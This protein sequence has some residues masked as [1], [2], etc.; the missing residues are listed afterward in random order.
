[1]APW[2]G[3]NPLETGRAGDAP[4]GR[5]TSRAGA[6]SAPGRPFPS[7]ALSAQRPAG[8]YFRGRAAPGGQAGGGAGATAPSLRSGTGGRREEAAGKD[9]TPTETSTGKRQ[10]SSPKYFI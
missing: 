10:G 4:R 1:M 6:R 2:E 7:P 3:R 5:G 8:R 9:G